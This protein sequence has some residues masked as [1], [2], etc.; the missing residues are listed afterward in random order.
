MFSL[1]FS[2]SLSD[3][4]FRCKH[5]KDI[6]VTPKLSPYGIY[7]PTYPSDRERWLTHAENL[8]KGRIFIPVICNHFDKLHGFSYIPR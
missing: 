7:D 1:V 2:R 6:E 3:D 5:F 4:R 8:L